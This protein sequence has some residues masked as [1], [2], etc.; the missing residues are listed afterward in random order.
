MTFAQPTKEESIDAP[1]E[2]FAQCKLSPELKAVV[3]DDVKKLGDRFA[4]TFGVLEKFREG[5]GEVGSYLRV[6]A[7]QYEREM[8]KAQHKLTWLKLSA[9][10]KTDNE[11]KNA[12]P[13]WEAAVES[14]DDAFDFTLSVF[15][16]AKG[17]EGML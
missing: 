2:A 4:H 14:F 16:M 3:D 13:S 17:F 5:K 6:M 7:K 11:F 12:T 10:Q 1:V 15:S 9:Y 8:I